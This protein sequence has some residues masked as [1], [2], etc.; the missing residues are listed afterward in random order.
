METILDCLAFGRDEKSYN[1]DV[2]SFCLTLHYYSPRA[3]N[4]LRSKFKNNIPSISA[5]RNWYS[6]I[7]ATP[8][9][10]DIAFESLR[11]MSE[12]YEA[13]HNKKLLCNVM[14]DDMAIRRHS[15]YNPSTMKFDGFIDIGR[16]L[17]G[18]NNL[19]LAKEALVF[20][21]S[22]VNE[23]FKIPVAYFLSNGL[24]G[25]ERADLTRNVLIRL[26][27]IGID[28][29]SL[30]F[31]GLR[32]NISMCVELG[33]NF[34]EGNGFIIDPSNENRKIYVILD[35]AHMLK[36][37][38]NCVGSK[39][40]IDSE[41]GV[42][43]WQYFSSLYEAQQN[44]PCNLGNKLSKAH[45]QWEKRKMCVRTAGE[46]LSNSVADSMDFMKQECRHFKDVEP[47][48]KYVRIVNDIFDIMNS[49]GK[50]GKTGFKR[51][52]TNDTAGE[53]F[54]RFEEAMEYIKGLK[55]D[56]E[57][58]PILHSI[59][60][61]P[62]FGFYNNMRNFML[63]FEE[64]VTTNKIPV[65]V[66]HRFSQDLLE[67]FFGTIRSMGGMHICEICSANFYFNKLL[68]FIIGFNDNPTAQQFEAAYRK[69]LV[70]NDVVCSNKAN[71]L[72]SGTKILSV[73]SN[74]ATEKK[75]QQK[76]ASTTE[77]NCNAIFVDEDYEDTF[78]VSQ[79]IDD[80]HSHSI[81]YMSSLI[82]SKIIN[83]KCPKLI[84][85]CEQCVNAFIQNELM[86]NSFIRFKA[87]KTDITHPCKSTFDICKCVD[88][89]LKAYE[90]NSVS[91]HSVLLQILRKIPFDTLYTSTHFESH[92]GEKSH[93]HKYN[94]VKKIIEMYMN[95]KSVYAAKCFTLKSHDEPVRHE[96]RKL[97][98]AKG[99]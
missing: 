51:P 33:A 28:V 2:R 21:V 32:A 81:A 16:K 47:T 34:D 85:K 53:F 19:P 24:N 56:G 57:N 90:E 12:D 79:Y 74:R 27:E 93:N 98:Q 17:E 76:T 1:E 63:I 31:D 45:M 70:H 3:Y 14:A 84:I 87:R 54:K 13:K 9:F 49:T 95:M 8:G 96:F 38:R 59:S 7:K 65:L 55:I 66:M 92:P 68:L 15:Q 73:S 89:F 18:Q 6:T 83:A 58:V 11:K 71:C 72:D 99:Q 30:I 78:N 69:L 25:T 36:L 94:L 77:N 42:I 22:G 35:A 88:I 20:L 64:Y 60:R 10:T 37:A 67:S 29:V 26:S 97:I 48:I 40:I 46:T 91:Y 61:T 50:E 86:Q 43:K 23:D 62:F 44:L 52:I 82:E 80:V 75:Q 4:Y 39:N 5:M 41:G